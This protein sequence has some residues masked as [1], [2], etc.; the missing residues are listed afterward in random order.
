VINKSTRLVKLALLVLIALVGFFLLLKPWSNS[1]IT[2]EKKG[3]GSV[4]SVTYPTVEVVDAVEERN[5]G[6]SEGSSVNLN[7]LKVT[8][9]QLVLVGTIIHEKPQRSLV[10][11]RVGQ[12]DISGVYH[13]GQIISDVALVIEIQRQLLIIKNL[14]NGKYEILGLGSFDSERSHPEFDSRDYHIKRQMVDLALSDLPKLLGEASTEP[15]LNNQG[16]VR[17]FRINWIK[18][19]SLFTHLGLKVGDVIKAVNDVPID[20]AARA[21]E[22]FQQ[23]KQSSMVRVNIDRAGNNLSTTYLIREE[24]IK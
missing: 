4:G 22:L 10:S 14:R 20:S 11:V 3:V 1:A 12:A 2:G 17:G 24:K 16:E 8:G 13:L 21:L 15:V 23:L 7:D 5:S 19:G 18:D 9:L 6:N